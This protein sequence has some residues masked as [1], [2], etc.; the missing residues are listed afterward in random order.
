[1]KGAAP[2]VAH[3]PSPAAEMPS[4]PDHYV[5]MGPDSMKTQV[6]ERRDALSPDLRPAGEAAHSLAL[7]LIIKLRYAVPAG[8]TLLILLAYFVFDVELPLT[9]VSIPL[10]LVAGSNW[11]LSRNTQ[12]FGNRHY[13]GSLLALDT[14]CLTAF[15]ALTGGPHNPF[16]LLYLVQITLSAVTLSREW[17]WT[18]GFLSNVCFG[19]LFLASVQVPM[20]EVHHMHGNFSPH[21]LGMWIAFAAATLLITIFVGKISDTLKQREQDVLS[22]QT[23]LAKHE[24][25]SSIVT[26]AAGAAHE[27]AT[28]LASIAIASRDLELHET[29]VSRDQDVTEDARM[30]RGEVERCNSILRRIGERGAELPGEA[31]VLLDLAELLE[32]VR[33]EL[34]VSHQTRIMT[35]VTGD[36]RSAFLPAE[37]TKIA[38]TSL[39]RNALDASTDDDTVFLTADATPRELRFSIVDSG[40][41]MGQDT[42]KR[43]GEPFFTTKAPGQGMGLG[44]FLVR[45]FA[46]R[47]H[48]SLFF[49]SEEERGT[50]AILE[51]PLIHYEDPR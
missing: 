20:L 6:L 39:V 51:L 33:V 11:L 23:R 16:T 19:F 5:R 35:L 48:G 4:R 45:G 14:L 36:N 30:I 1:M 15:L 34:A 41:G 29:G 9:W 7:P 25:L 28:P 13:L 40:H 8:E 50:K 31:P 43:L 3:I 18:L 24:R 38:L 44:I 17:T 49:E 37:A 21:L 46:E 22:L 12:K 42:M 32:K 26:L 10:V 27:L 47:L 2:G